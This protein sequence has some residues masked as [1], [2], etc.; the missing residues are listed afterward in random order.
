MKSRLF[1]MT[2]AAVA[3]VALCA[4]VV[5]TAGAAPANTVTVTGAVIG[6]GSGSSTWMKPVSGA[7]IRVEGATETA[8]TASDG[9]YSLIAI[10]PGGPTY[11]FGKVITASHPWY[12]TGHRLLTSEPMQVQTFLLRVKG[13][14]FVVTVKSGSKRVKGA[15]VSCF[16]KSA[17]SNSHG[18]ATLSGL[19]LKPQ[20]KYTIKIRKSG[21][22][23]S[24]FKVTSK[25]GGTKNITKNITKS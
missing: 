15:K 3:L 7:T 11:Y 22:H 23:N 13:T 12:Q 5:G 1:K 14:K 4:T 21:Y 9:I 19:Q 8:T 17:T 20:A 18:V 6:Y 16:G 24:N 2:I 25:P 10:V